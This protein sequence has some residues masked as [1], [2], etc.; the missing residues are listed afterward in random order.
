MLKISILGLLLL[1]L[2]V[3]VS[4]APALKGI[5]G[6]CALDDLLILLD[7]DLSS[8]REVAPFPKVVLDGLVGSHVVVADEVAADEGARAGLALV[9]VDEHA[10]APLLDVQ[11]LLEHGL[12]LPQGGV[13]ALLPGLANDPEAQLGEQ[14]GVVGVL[15]GGREAP[16]AALVLVRPL[17]VEDRLHPQ[18][19]Q[20]VRH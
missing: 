10:L 12:Q 6:E 2:V 20:L 1:P 16:S 7:K 17:Q 19:Y 11:H 9:A 18:R 15:L 14:F 3:V 13:H 4:L 8:V 5:A